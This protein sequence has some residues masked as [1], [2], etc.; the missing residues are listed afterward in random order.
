MFAASML[1][2]AMETY[3]FLNNILTMYLICTALVGMIQWAV[4]ALN[5]KQYRLAIVAVGAALCMA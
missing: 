3:T 1:V 5:S 2:V 4:Q